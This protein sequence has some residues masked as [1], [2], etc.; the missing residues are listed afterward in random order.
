[1][2]SPIFWIAGAAAGAYYLLD[3]E[4]KETVKDIAVEKVQEYS[5]ALKDM[6][7]G[8]KQEAAKVFAANIIQKESPRMLANPEYRSKVISAQV[9]RD[10]TR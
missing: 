5:K 4:Q 9:A 7:V 8:E 2:V 3:K 10:V 1:M 6:T